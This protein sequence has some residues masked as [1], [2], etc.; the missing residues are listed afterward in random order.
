MKVCLLAPTPPPAGGIAEWTKRMLSVE[1]KNRWEI[2]LVNERT[3]DDRSF[4]VLNFRRN[5][6]IEIIRCV[7]IWTDLWHSLND[8]NVRVVHSCIPAGTLSLLRELISLSIT[9]FRKRKF[10]IHF[11]C[12]TENMVKTKINVMLYNRMI[13]KSDAAIYLNTQSLLFSRK[14]YPNGNCRVIPNFINLDEINDKRIHSSKIQTALYVGGVIPQK[15]CLLI[16]DVAR[17]LPEITFRLVGRIGI[18]TENLP[19]NVILTGE[20]SHEQIKQEYNKADVFLFLSHYQG[21]GF[22]NAL[23]EAMAAAL[24]CI[25]TD[26]AANHDMIQQDGGVVLRNADTKT[27]LEAFDYLEPIEKRKKMGD[28]NRNRAKLCYSQNFVTSSYVDLYEEIINS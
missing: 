18:S 8:K 11:R 5:Y 12:T 22:S 14:L 16:I 27:V 9:H 13:K 25:V 3:L 4:F 20:K 19:P 28:Y 23:A 1:L 2:V 24:P 15:G 10:I 6:F 7:K 17:L 26:W 21:E